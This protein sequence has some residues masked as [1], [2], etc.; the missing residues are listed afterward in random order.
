MSLFKSKA[1]RIHPSEPT[2]EGVPVL[3]LRKST[4]GSR[5]HQVELVRPRP[6][7]RNGSPC[8]EEKPFTASSGLM[9]IQ[10]TEVYGAKAGG[11]VVH[12]RQ[13]VCRMIEMPT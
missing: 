2:R 13:C 6:W 3:A 9:E 10:Y 4:G 5:R 7:T 12:A 8:L 11:D 1:S